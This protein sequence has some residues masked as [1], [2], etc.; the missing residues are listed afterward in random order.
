MSSRYGRYNAALRGL[1]LSVCGVIACAF[2][3]Y[4]YDLGADFRR[5][6]EVA[7][8]I[9]YS[10]HDKADDDQQKALR[11][12]AR[13]AA[14]SDAGLAVAL[15][16]LALSI[17]G[18]AGVGFTVFYARLAWRESKRSADVARDALNHMRDDATEQGARFDEQAALAHRAADSAAS[19]AL[20]MRRVARAMQDNVAAVAQTV[21]TN[22]E[23]AAR[24][25]QL[26]EMQLRAFVSVA[27]GPSLYQ[28]RALNIRFGSSPV[29]INSGATP[30]RKIR[31]RIKAAVLPVPFPSDFKFSLPPPNKGEAQLAAHDNGNMEVRVDDW[32]GDFEVENIKR[33][34]GK[35]L[36]VWGVV[37]YE[38]AFKKLRRVTFCQQLYW[39]GHPP[40]EVVRGW[41]L[42]RHNRSN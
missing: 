26:G 42:A 34:L 39:L 17:L 27:I 3:L 11:I 22:K 21:E 33:N 24:Q 10:H 36:Y 41:R 18:F 9:P 19:S 15:G 1:G 29:M 38:D 28:D 31:F 8:P 12:Q 4:V 40:N 7:Y 37:T 30:A 2:A 5:L 20:A 16:Q 13:E 14:T 6:R 25:K 32:V 23:I 35:A